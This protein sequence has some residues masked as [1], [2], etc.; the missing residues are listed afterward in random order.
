M[1]HEGGGHFY[2]IETP[3]QITDLLTSELGEALEV[4]ARRAAL[5]VVLP[6]GADAEPLNR[7]RFARAGTTSLRVEL[8]DLVSG[9]ELRAVIRVKFP[10]GPLGERLAMRVGLNADGELMTRDDSIVGWTYASHVDN[11][12]QPRDREVDRE[13]ARLYSAR[14]RA[15]A[16]EANREGDFNRAQIILEA[17]AR[18]IMTYAGDDASLQS[19]AM[20]LKQD[21]LEFGAAMH[22]QRIKEH[23]QAAL[24][25]QHGRDRLGKAHRKP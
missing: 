25:L 7:F 19:I 12:R 9:Q 2:F 21:H 4:V 5:E 22:S 1:A 8:G 11:D 10:R 3:A 15:D 24:V 17:T 20:E 13:V 16:T 6:P 18:R 23:F 14:A